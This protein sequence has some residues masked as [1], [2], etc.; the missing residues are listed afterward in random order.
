VKC[1][2][3]EAA[4]EIIEAYH[5]DPLYLKIL[6]V[7]ICVGVIHARYVFRLEKKPCPAVRKRRIDRTLP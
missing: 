2:S 7:V 1:G 3:E 6:N 5:Q 4:R